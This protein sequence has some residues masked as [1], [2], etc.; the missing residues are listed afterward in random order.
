MK[1]VLQM[2]ETDLS[3]NETRNN[4]T[5]TFHA[6]SLTQVLEKYQDFLKGC[7]FVF[8]GQLDIV[9]DEEFYGYPEDDYEEE[10]N[11]ELIDLAA[12]QHSEHYYDTERN[13]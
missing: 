4:V 11:L 2:I 1:Y 10:V 9:P 7:G 8:Q 13:K 12:E 5:F 6:D 3:G